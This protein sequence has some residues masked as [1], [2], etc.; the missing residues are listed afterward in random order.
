MGENYFGIS[1]AYSLLALS[2]LA[3]AYVFLT[4]RGVVGAA[5]T[6]CEDLST[7]KRTCQRRIFVPVAWSL[8][9]LSTLLAAGIGASLHE[10]WGGLVLAGVLGL[11]LPLPFCAAVGAAV[12]WICYGAGPERAWASLKRF[13]I[14][15]V[16]G[17]LA[18]VTLGH[19]A[20]GAF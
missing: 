11:L 14:Q 1:D 16:L 18:L 5:A 17:Y 9:L 20:S 3:F 8:Y 7:W 12:A 4:V 19:L 10:D 15:L 2:G 6:K 13:T